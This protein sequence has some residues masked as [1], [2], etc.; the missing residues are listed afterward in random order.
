MRRAPH[1]TLCL[2]LCAWIVLLSLSAGALLPALLPLQAI[3][4]DQPLTPEQQATYQ[5][6]LDDA[7][8][9]Y[10]EG[11]F[12]DAAAAFLRAYDIKPN[13]KI[14]YNVALLY[15]GLNDTANAALYYQKFADSPDATGKTKREA[16]EKVGAIHFS[17]K[18]YPSALTSFE[19]A[20]EAENTPAGQYNIARTIE[21]QGKFKEAL[22]IY[23][24]VVESPDLSLEVRK[25]VIDR[26]KTIRDTLALKAQP[27]PKTPPKTRIEVIPPDYTGPI[28]TLSAGGAL[29]LGGVVFGGIS[30]SKH[31]DFEAATS[32]KERQ[33]A[34]DTG[35]TFAAVGD[36]LWISGAVA[37][38][39]GLI[40][41]LLLKPTEREVIIDDA[42]TPTSFY[43]LPD[44]SPDRLG[45]GLS[46]TF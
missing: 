13:S 42:A 38:T 39:G 43:I 21:K 9:A 16:L 37:A 32:L 2:G 6:A 22:D 28:I 3:A 15:E 8:A 30:A 19:R 44:L 5:A 27:D 26:I 11:R 1:N 40:W 25:E 4:Q 34:S 14:L 18:D 46:L 41:L 36:A 45:L 20:F 17:N 7:N 31:S 23:E 10:S 12:A 33:D 35:A 29:I 24:K